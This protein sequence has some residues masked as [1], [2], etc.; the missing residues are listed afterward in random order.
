MEEYSDVPSR[1]REDRARLQ[2]WY[3]N[4]LDRA[5]EC[6][7]MLLEGTE[8]YGSPDAIK[9][10][11]FKV[12]RGLADP[13]QGMRYCQLEPRFL[14]KLGIKWEPFVR[15]GRKLVPLYEVTL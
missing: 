15:P 2:A 10:S 9:R 12:G 8:A 4:T 5:F 1:Y 11:Y 13:K 3:G 6:T 14:A 7:A